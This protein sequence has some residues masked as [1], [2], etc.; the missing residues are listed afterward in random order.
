LTEVQRVLASS[1]ASIDGESMSNPSVITYDER[2]FE[3]YMPNCSTP[4]T[5]SKRTGTA[6]EIALLARDA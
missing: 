6:L 2:W 5:G 1:P 4:E 3:T